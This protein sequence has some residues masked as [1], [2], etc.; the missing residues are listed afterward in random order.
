VCWS[1]DAGRTWHQEV[2]VTSAAA[3][4]WERHHPQ[5]ILSLWQTPEGQVLAGAGNG[6]LTS[7]DGRVWRRVPGSDVG[8]TALSVAGRAGSSWGTQD[9]P[10]FVGTAAGVLR[11]TTGGQT[12]QRLDGG[13]AAPYVFALRAQEGPG[14][15]RI[16]AATSTGLFRLDSGTTR[17]GLVQGGWP[18]DAAAVSLAVAGETVVV[19][20]DSGAYRSDD[21]GRDW[22]RLYPGQGGTRRLQTG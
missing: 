20:T 17:W 11:S 13:M 6:L 9:A 19:G 1:A 16:W 3:E 18:V 7:A 2:V 15:T 21:G 14:G 5:P 4:Q 22:R 10:L 8:I 12:W